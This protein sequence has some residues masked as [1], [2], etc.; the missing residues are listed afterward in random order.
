MKFC[1]VCKIELVKNV[2]WGLDT[3]LLCK[4]DYNINRRESYYKNWEK[5][6]QIIKK[7]EDK[8]NK[9]EHRKKQL[10]ETSHKML[11]KYPEKWHARAKLHYAIRK[12]E[13]KKEAC[14]CG[15]IKVHAHHAWGY[16]GENAL[17]VQWLCLRHHGEVHRKFK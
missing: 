10:N 2:N 9:T 7:Y 5:K 8:N 17:K 12:G 13:I 1:K 3:T 4:K 6:R 11:L 15:E 14:Y 16:D